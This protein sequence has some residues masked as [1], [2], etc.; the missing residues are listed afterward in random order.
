M[1]RGT[2]RGSRAVLS[3]SN[4]AQRCQVHFSR[5]LLDFIPKKDKEKITK[6]IA[7]ILESP[8]HYFVS[9]RVDEIITKYQDLYPKF[10]KKLEKG[11]EE[12]CLCLISVLCIDQPRRKRTKR[13][14]GGCGPDEYVSHSYDFL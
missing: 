10:S 13:D 12:A 5:N 2:Q 6:E 4:L 9:A 3:G 7:G 11:V 8:D 1:I 14:S